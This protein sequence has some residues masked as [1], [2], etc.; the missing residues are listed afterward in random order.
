MKKYE[1][2]H[3]C[4]QSNLQDITY[5][6]TK[7]MSNN[8]SQTELL[9]QSMEIKDP[10]KI[11][12]DHPSRKFNP[13]YSVL[14]FL[15]YLSA[16]KKTNNIGKCAN[17]WLKIQDDQE[18]V[19]SNYGT[20]ILGEQWD[21]ILNEFAHDKDSRRCTIVIHQ[22]HHKTKNAKDLPCTQYLQFFIRDNK[23]HLG[24]NM[25]SNDIIF[26]FCNDVFNFVLFQQLMLNELKEIYPNLQLGS[27]HHQAGSLHLYEQH[28]NMRDNILMDNC[29][30]ENTT[31]ELHPYITREYIQKL[32]IALPIEDLP[33]LELLAFTKNQ[34]K[35]LFI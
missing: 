7:V 33:K 27:Y 12:I 14:E 29:F 34:M 15:W 30:S 20:Y 18:E 3:D 22:P 5:N 10:T 2:L 21:W 8:S 4:F 32:N 19:E 35:K 23:L 24:V 6:G 17:I 13:V 9:F 1:N 26:G 16:H 25:R 11:S 28:Y 31:Y